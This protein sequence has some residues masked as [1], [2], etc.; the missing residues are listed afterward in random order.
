MDCTIRDS[1]PG[2]R[3]GLI[4]S[5]KR[6]DG[7]CGPPRILFNR[8]RGLLLSGLKRPENEADHSFPSTAEAKKEFFWNYTYISPSWR[9]HGKLFFY[10]ER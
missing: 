9:E 10:Q 5:S 3:Y 7:N 1:N 6:Q 2:R 8:C 4:S